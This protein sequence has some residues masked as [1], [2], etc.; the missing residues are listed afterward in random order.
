MRTIE[1]RVTYAEGEPETVRVTARDINSG[2]AK[3]VKRAREPLG[4][5][6]VRQL[7]SVEFWLAQ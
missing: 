4:F 2:F 7:H 6:R 1:Y 5:G 3:A